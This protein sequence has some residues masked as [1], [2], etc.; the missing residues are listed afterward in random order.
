ML[1]L[2]LHHRLRHQTQ[3]SGLGG[4]SFVFWYV[5]KHEAKARVGQVCINISPTVLKSL[6]SVDLFGCMSLARHLLRVG[7]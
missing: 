1:Y 3:A 4:A 5:P 7:V 2:H 6:H